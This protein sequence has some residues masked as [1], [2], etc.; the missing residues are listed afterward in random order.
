MTECC[1]AACS[2]RGCT[3]SV[4]SPYARELSLLPP[5]SKLLLLQSV[6]SADNAH[7]CDCEWVQ[8][9]SSSWDER[10]KARA[11]QLLAKNRCAEHG[12]VSL[13]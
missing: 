7:A 10:K 2:T 13:V 3:Q 11:R 6:S 4:L 9:D 8:P 12:N 5:Y 1:S